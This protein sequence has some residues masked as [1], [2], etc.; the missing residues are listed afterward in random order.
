MDVKTKVLLFGAPADCVA[1]TAAAARLAERL[2][3]VF[4][5]QLEAQLVEATELPTGCSNELPCP[6]PAPCGGGSFCGYGNYYLS[7]EEAVANVLRERPRPVARPYV[8]KTIG[9]P[10]RGY[11]ATYRQW[12]R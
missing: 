3:I 2:D 9:T 7:I 12:R 11:A 4:V 6:E 10:Y 8:P 5:E 1:L